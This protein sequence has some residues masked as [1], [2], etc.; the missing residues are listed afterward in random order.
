[1]V[2]T[3]P[4]GA[5]RAACSARSWEALTSPTSA[6]VGSSRPYGWAPYI[7]CSKASRA[8]TAA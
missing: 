8:T 4:A 7:L 5:I 1:M 3:L 2:R 6:A